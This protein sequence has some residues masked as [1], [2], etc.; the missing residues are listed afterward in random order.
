TRTNDAQSLL[1][2][3]QY[4]GQRITANRRG[5]RGSDQAAFETLRHRLN[6]SERI[7]QFVAQNADD[8][9]PR[10]AFFIAQCPAQVAQDDQVVRQ[11]ALPER[12]AAQSPASRATGERVPS[13]GWAHLP[14]TRRVLVLPL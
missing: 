10:F 14:G 11:A 13:C 1:Q 5:F 7:V 8:L 9:L 6:G 4:C 12:A 2:V 3:I